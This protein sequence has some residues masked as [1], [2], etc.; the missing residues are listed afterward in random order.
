[1]KNITISLLLF[2]ITMYAH[3][4][5]YKGFKGYVPITHISPGQLRYTMQNV[6][7]KIKKLLSTHS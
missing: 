1:M 5:L 6:Q 2:S 4:C 7:T 3:T